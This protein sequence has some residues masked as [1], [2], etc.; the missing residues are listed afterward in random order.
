MKLKQTPDG[1]AL[2]PNP[3][4]EPK[5]SVLAH[6]RCE[7]TY[8]GFR[9]N[10]PG[11]VSEHTTMYCS[12]HASPPNRAWDHEQ[13]RYIHETE[14]WGFAER[15]ILDR[16]VGTVRMEL[17]KVLRGRW[18]ADRRQE[19]ESR[20]EYRARMRSTVRELLSA[21]RGRSKVEPVG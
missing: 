19:D 5:P 4:R 20:S 18:K 13:G 21:F 12:Y 1:W 14:S 7:F 8:Q 2:V 11:T 9:C 6:N 16:T 10:A 3:D 15:F 17:Y